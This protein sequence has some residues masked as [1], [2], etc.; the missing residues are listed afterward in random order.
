MF[1]NIANPTDAEADP[2]LVSGDARTEACLNPASWWHSIHEVISD[3]FVSYGDNKVLR[4]AIKELEQ[5]LKKGWSANGGV[6]SRVE[7]LEGPTEAH[8]QPIVDF[9]TLGSENKSNTRVAIE[10]WYKAGLRQ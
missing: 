10:E 9:M 8:V 5:H 3:V 2:G 1:L 6:A 4:D 7:F